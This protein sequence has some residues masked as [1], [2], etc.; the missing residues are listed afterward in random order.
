MLSVLFVLLLI[1]FGG[2][3]AYCADRLGRTLGKKRLS[4]LGLR[5]RHTAE[6][7]TVMAGA[8]IPIVTFAIVMAASADVREW[9]LHSPE[10]KRDRDKAVADLTGAQAELKRVQNDL[11]KQQNVLCSINHTMDGLKLRETS[12]VNEVSAKTTQAKKAEG[13]YRQ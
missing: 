3:I 8:V 11:G 5:P 2:V 9:I 10:Y 13:Q 7:L 4:L 12:L 1:F 6:V